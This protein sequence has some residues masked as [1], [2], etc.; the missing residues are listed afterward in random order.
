[1]E[2]RW[3]S[4]EN[5]K[6]LNGKDTIEDPEEIKLL[7][8]VKDTG[9]GIRLDAHGRIFTPFV[10]ADSSTSRHYGGT[11]IGLSISKHLVEL[12]HGEIGFVSEPGIG[13]TFSFTGAFG[14]GE[15][16]SLDSKWK[17][18]DPVVSEFQG[19][20]ALIIDNRSIRAEVTKYHLRRL[21]I[22]VDIISSM[23]SAYTYLSSTCGASAIAHLAM[24]LIDKD[25][26]NQE[27]VLQLRSLLKEHRQNGRLDVSTNLPK[28]TSMSPVERSKLKTSGFV[29]N[30]LMKPLRLSV[31][32]ACFQEALGNGRKDQI[33][34]KKMSTL[35][36]LLREKQILVV[37]DVGLCG[38][39]FGSKVYFLTDDN[40]VNRRVAEGALKKY[41]ALVSCVERGQDALDKLKPPH[42]FDACFMDLQMPEMD[43]FEAT[44]QIRSAEREVNDKIARGEASVEMYGNMS[45]WQ[46]PILALTA[47]V[48]Q[49]T[50]E[51]CM[52]CGM[53]DHVS[54][55]FE[56]EQLYSAV[57]RFFEST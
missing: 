36:T 51:E 20:G 41:G 12:M 23:E 53:D 34:R 45:H 8:T 11:G 15:V 46:I 39:K 29:D 22:S 26:W 6:I 56:E 18:Y 16:S 42:N 38:A 7:V 25:V 4:W 40:K 19:L 52:K 24:I 27:T 37:D 33:H 55:P 35:G 13:S 57:A 21:G 50:N 9:V 54:K 17:Q 47:D 2:D 48:I 32:I 43:G 14:K 49:A 5:F 44:R 28:I 30:V 1:M 10:Q 3:R 31:F